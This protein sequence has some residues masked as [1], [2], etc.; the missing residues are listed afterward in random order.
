[1]AEMAGLEWRDDGDD[2]DNGDGDD[3]DRDGVEIG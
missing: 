3:E 2:G 1:M